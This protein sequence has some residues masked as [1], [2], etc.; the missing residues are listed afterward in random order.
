MDT[1]IDQVKSSVSGWIANSK[2]SDKTAL[3]IF[4]SGDKASITE[5]ISAY[6]INY[7]PQQQG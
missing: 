5:L 2:Y 3:E 6:N 4:Q 7:Q 1:Y